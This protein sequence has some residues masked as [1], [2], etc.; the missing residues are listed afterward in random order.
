MGVTEKFTDFCKKLEFSSDE[1]TT[2][3][4]RFEAICKRLNKDFWDMDSVTGGKFVGSVGRK[5]A[6]GWES[7]ID[8]LFEMPSAVYNQYNA[9]QGNGQSALLQAVKNSISITYPNTDVGGDGQV[10]VV[11]FTDSLRFE[12]LPAWK[13]SLGIYTYADSNNGGSWKTTNPNAEIAAIE[14]GQLFTNNNLIN[15]CRMLR[16]WKSYNSVPIGGLLLDTLAYNFL[17]NW[18]NRHQSYL[19]YDFMTRDFFEYLKNVNSTSWFAIGSGA[20]LTKQGE[21]SG[22]A[23]KAY[24]TALEAIEFE[25]SGLASSANSKWRDIYGLRFPA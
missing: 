19:Y 11:P 5:T 22:K 16:A 6:N 12:V 10:V 7:D 20:V 25:N 8:M 18:Y 24:K 17:T 9:Y 15:L 21:F 4:S 23:E 3:Q 2:I 1:L 14:T 13:N